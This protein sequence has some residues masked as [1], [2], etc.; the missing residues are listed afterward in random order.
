M[1]KQVKLANKYFKIEI[2]E[3]ENYEISFFLS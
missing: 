3:L 1:M 2:V